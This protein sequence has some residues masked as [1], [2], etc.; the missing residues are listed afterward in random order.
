[1]KTKF[2]WFESRKTIIKK[3]FI[4]SFLFT[5]VSLIFKNLNH[6]F[7]NYIIL[8]ISL[9]SLSYIL[10]IHHIQKTSILETTLKI[11]LRNIALYIGLFLITLLFNINDI[12]F[13]LK[14]YINYINFVVITLVTYQLSKMIISTIHNK[15]KNKILFVGNQEKYYECLT[16]LKIPTLNNNRYLKLENFKN[17]DL[18]KLDK[19][20]HILFDVQNYDDSQEPKID[21][22]F[23]NEFK[24]YTIVE[25]AELILQRYPI[26]L[27]E[28][29][30]ELNFKKI[31][32]PNTY[33]LRIKRLSEIII[34]LSLII[35]TSPIILFFSIL[36]Y[37]EDRGP[38][39]YSQE[40]TGLNGKV[41]KIYKLRTMIKNAEK[42][43]AIWSMSND[44]RITKIGSLLRR[45]RIDELPQLISVI[46]GDMSL[47]GPRPE[48]PS[49]NKE[50][51]KKILFYNIRH[52][53]KPGISGW[54]QVNYPYGSSI[55]DAEAK[56]S[57]DLYYLKHFSNFLDLLIFI[58]TIR[59]VINADGAISKN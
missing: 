35:I 16:V 4:D 56:L 51:E 52:Q 32:S 5:I 47:I 38:I 1:M 55:K 42:E 43:G 25:W 44:K 17:V 22:F 59:L 53:I 41:F 45:L 48:R 30:K 15:T 57:F 20:W 37:I 49:I 14:N 31:Y 46:K 3:Y 50:L 2:P 13:T 7:Y 40:R 10:D 11:L 39:L 33:E 24:V 9:N 36:V 21:Y 23:K 12:I 58:K 8:L 27:L 6:F 29:E 19:K 26:K 54:A 28:K 34:S 18:K